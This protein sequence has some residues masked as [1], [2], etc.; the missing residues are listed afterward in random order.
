MVPLIWRQRL[1][2]KLQSVHAQACQT[3]GVTILMLTT[4]RTS[5]PVN[6]PNY[7]LNLSLNLGWT[8]GRVHSS[9]PAMG[10]STDK[11]VYAVLVLW[12][13]GREQQMDC[14]VPSVGDKNICRKICNLRTASLVTGQI[15]CCM[16]LQ[17]LKKKNK[18]VNIFRWPSI[19]FVFI[20]LTLIGVNMSLA[21][22]IEILGDVANTND[23]WQH[24][25]WF[26]LFD[27]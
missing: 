21:V 16:R 27:K 10:N 11:K 8:Y 24:A 15:C 17:A 1:V 25:R 4:V 23:K 5:D 7:L 3:K 14:I 20:S 19:S 6:S 13:W 2:P 9:L 22:A 12:L 18:L 26:N